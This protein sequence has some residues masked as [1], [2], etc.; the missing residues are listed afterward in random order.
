MM[1][2]LK[3]REQGRES[4]VIGHKNG[5]LTNYGCRFCPTSRQIAK[6]RELD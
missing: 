6:D 4:G 3:F 5:K 1:I 2:Y